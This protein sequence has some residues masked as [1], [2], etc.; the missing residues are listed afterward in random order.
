[1]SYSKDDARFR[2]EALE[3]SFEEMFR[4]AYEP[5]V[6]SLTVIAG[7]REVAA[8]CVADAFERAYVRW[9]RIR[10]YED[11]VGW[12]RRVAINRARD[13]ARRAATA[14]RASERLEPVESAWA[15]DVPPIDLAQTLRSLPERQQVAAALYYVED[16]PVSE[17]A[18]AMGI[19]DGAVKFHLH[20]AR[21]AL[22]ARLE[23]VVSDE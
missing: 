19:S 18:T 20:A 9:W 2:E 17:I 11:P 7:D 23:A 3:P 22:R 4:A 13:H 5:L 12:V 10:R 8:D 15:P 16:L 14:R 21:K 6:R 1:M